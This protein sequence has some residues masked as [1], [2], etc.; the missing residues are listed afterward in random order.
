MNKNKLITITL[1]FFFSVNTLFAGE[2]HRYKVPSYD[3]IKTKVK[4]IKLEIQRL[5]RKIEKLMVK[6][7]E[8]IE[9]PQTPR[10][11]IIN[12]NDKMIYIQ[13]FYAD[14]LFKGIDY[15]TNKNYKKFQFIMNNSSAEIK[16]N[17]KLIR[18]KSKNT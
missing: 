2:D 12:E 5:K 16:K 18:K 14:V 10:K 4:K 8:K 17:F 15:Y 6:L 11:I 3:Q 13:G 9:Y 1:I 7:K